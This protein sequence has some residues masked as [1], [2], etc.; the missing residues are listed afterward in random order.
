MKKTYLFYLAQWSQL[1]LDTGNSRTL[2]MYK[3]IPL[4]LYHWS[5][6]YKKY[7]YIIFKWNIYFPKNAFVFCCNTSCSSSSL[8]LCFFTACVRKINIQ[9]LEAQKHQ[10][11]LKQ[12]LISKY[13]SWFIQSERLFLTFEVIGLSSMAT[14][15]LYMYTVK[16]ILKKNVWHIFR[17]FIRKPKEMFQCCINSW[18]FAM[19]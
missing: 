10:Q 1:L 18:T 9:P 14:H 15:F 3:H 19:Q 6:N 4:W 7:I 13:N 12:F 2:Y 17:T 8:T 5:S 11:Q 16:H